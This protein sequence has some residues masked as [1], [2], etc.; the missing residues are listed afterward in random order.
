MKLTFH[1]ISI[2]ANN[3]GIYCINKI[4]PDV[5]GKITD[6][7]RQELFDRRFTL[8]AVYFVKW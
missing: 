2:C 7:Y 8:K 1:R 6:Y 3:R 4:L 5:G